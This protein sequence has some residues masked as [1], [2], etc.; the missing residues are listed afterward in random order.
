M[1]EVPL[2]LSIGVGLAMLAELERVG[3]IH[4]RTGAGV[5]LRL[6]FRGL[7]WAVQPRRGFSIYDALY[8]DGLF[9]R[10]VTSA[11]G[12]ESD[13]ALALGLGYQLLPGVRGRSFGAF[14]GMR[15]E[16]EYWEIGD[17]TASGWSFPIAFRSEARYHETRWLMVE[18]W[19]SVFGDRKASGIELDIGVYARTFLALWLSRTTAEVDLPEHGLLPATAPGASWKALVG[20]RA[21]SIY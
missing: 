8:S 3:D 14:A 12:D 16:L 20:L 18:A 10:R 9:G 11:V 21:G 19:A 7:S 5:D 2:R 4:P 15:A 17:S 6:E 1:D 13:A